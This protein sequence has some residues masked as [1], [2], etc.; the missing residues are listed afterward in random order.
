MLAVVAVSAYSAFTAYP[1]FVDD[2][3]TLLSTMLF[4]MPELM[5]ST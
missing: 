2:G 3:I 4:V 5:A 1:G